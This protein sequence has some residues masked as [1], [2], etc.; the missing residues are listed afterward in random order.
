LVGVGAG[1]VAESLVIPLILA[2]EYLLMAE[3]KQILCRD[4]GPEGLRFFHNFFQ[5]ISVS[6]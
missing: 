3:S 5:D 1:D 4:E 6:L 2:R